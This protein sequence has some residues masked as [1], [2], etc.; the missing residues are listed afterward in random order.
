MVRG[1]IRQ[2]S[3]LNK[4]TGSF[5]LMA[6]RLAGMQAMIVVFIALGWWIKGEIESLSVLLGGIAYLLP[7]LYFAYCLFNTSRF[8]TSSPIKVKQTIVNF[9][10]GEV[11]KLTL[12]AGL[13]IIIILYIPVS[14]VPFIMGLVGTKFGF[15]L[16][17]L[18]IKI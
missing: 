18:V 9:Y 4:E 7:N 17:P 10:L 16:A 13:V 12:S 5:L 11:I 15:F 6:Y 2:Q 14:I 3:P 1:G 8:D